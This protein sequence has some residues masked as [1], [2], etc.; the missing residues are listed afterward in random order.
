MTD[1]LTPEQTA[2]FLANNSENPL[3]VDFFLH[4]ICDKIEHLRFDEKCYWLD[5]RE[6]WE[7]LKTYDV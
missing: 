3:I 7:R 6:E 4:K 2:D 5:V 1:N